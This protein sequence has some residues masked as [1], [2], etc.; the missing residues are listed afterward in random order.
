MILSKCVTKVRVCNEPTWNKGHVY[1][2]NSY[3]LISYQV[4]HGI[5]LAK[6]CTKITD[7]DS[8]QKLMNLCDNMCR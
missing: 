3:V 1:I 4:L 6:Q 2:S 5:C 7:T 8:I